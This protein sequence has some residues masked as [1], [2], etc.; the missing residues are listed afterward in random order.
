MRIYL[1]NFA[2]VSRQIVQKSSANW[3]TEIVNEHVDGLIEL[4][5][6]FRTL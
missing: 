6:C 4:P 5:D 3:L 1:G 2:I